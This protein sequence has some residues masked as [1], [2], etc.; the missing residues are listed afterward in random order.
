V[1]LGR[2]LSP[3]ALALFWLA[4]A[5]ARATESAPSVDRG[6]QLGVGPVVAATQV[7]E[8]LVAPLRWVGPG[9]GITLSH[10]YRA[11]TWDVEERLRLALAYVSERYGSSNALLLPA[12]DVS[13]HFGSAGRPGSIDFGAW[14]GVHQLLGYYVAWDD[15][16]LYWFTTVG[17]GPSVRF[18]ADTLPRPVEIEVSAPLVALV[19]RPPRRRLY[20]VDNLV[21]PGFLFG[22]F[23]HEP[24]L[25]SVH[26]LQAASI[27]ATWRGSRTAFRWDPW[28]ELEGETYSE[29]ARVIHVSLWLGGEARWGL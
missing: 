10:D 3:L 7:R 5:P 6:H 9:F 29:P 27:R 28:V 1:A 13:A 17:L 4:A 24:E 11:A 26:R 23:A 16:H 19:S 25:T 2:R 14:F 12:F 22:R 8:D 20:K 15:A 21:S 18:T